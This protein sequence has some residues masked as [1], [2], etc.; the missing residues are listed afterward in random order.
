V[1]FGCS[2]IGVTGEILRAL[3]GAT[4]FVSTAAPDENQSDALAEG[5]GQP[6]DRHFQ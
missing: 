2:F 1:T 5:E 3:A 4:R 6:T